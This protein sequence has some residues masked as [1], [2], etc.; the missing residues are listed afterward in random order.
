MYVAVPHQRVR[1]SRQLSCSR[2]AVREA[3]RG[4]PAAC[5]MSIEAGNDQSD[6]PE[7][8]FRFSRNHRAGDR[9]RHAPGDP[10]HATGRSRVCRRRC[11]SSAQ[12]TRQGEERS[13]ALKV[14]R[15]GSPGSWWADLDPE[16][17]TELGDVAGRPHVVLRKLDRAVALRVHVDDER[18]PQHADDGLAV[19]HLLAERSVRLEHGLV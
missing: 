3:I 2:F 14:T 15:A 5:S 8:R 7:D 17:L 10:G 18:R 6:S 4:L 16:L 19:Q 9:L 1:A 12:G 11:A 13:T